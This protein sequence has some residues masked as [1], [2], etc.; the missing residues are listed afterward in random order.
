MSRRRIG[1]IASTAKKLAKSGKVKL[2]SSP[3]DKVYR[4]IKQVFA[5]ETSR[6][7]TFKQG[8]RRHHLHVVDPVAETEENTQI[9][10][11]KTI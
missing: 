9:L 7:A 2:S 3:L 8:L 4:D 5:M 10:L 1:A 6:D 11:I